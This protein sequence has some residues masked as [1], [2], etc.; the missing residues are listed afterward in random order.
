MAEKGSES[1]IIS[2]QLV[3][4]CNISLPS[5]RTAATLPVTGGKLF[6][7]SSA[8]L[9]FS[10]QDQMVVQQFSI[11]HLADNL[12]PAYAVKLNCNIC[13]C[14][15]K[16]LSTIVALVNTYMVGYKND[17]RVYLRNAST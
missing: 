17:R 13:F 5:S 11:L 16:V 7:A 8:A 10:R 9:P 14:V 4:S 1:E 15:S 2:E 3:W 12:S 6:N